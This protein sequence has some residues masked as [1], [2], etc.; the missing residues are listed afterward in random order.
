M[1]AWLDG[2]LVA[3]AM[4][5]RA[6]SAAPGPFETMGARRGEIASWD[7]HLAR[8]G[9]A[10]RRLG[11]PFVPD[12]KLRAAATELLLHNGHGD[13][14]LRLSLVPAAGGAH[15]VLVS[16]ARG[17]ALHVVRLLPTVVE[18]PANEPPRDLKLWP[19]PFYDA[20]RQQAQDGAADDGIVVAPDGAVLE[21][22]VGNLWLRLDGVW[23]T[24][25]LDGRVL[26][27]I[28]RAQVLAAARAQGLPVAERRCDLADLHRAEALAHSNAVF[29]PRPAAL[30]GVPLPTVPYVDTELWPLWRA[31][32]RD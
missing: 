6:T 15:T 24:P 16:R 5:P 18:P 25:P 19:R 10:A 28:A 14:V 20:V 2:A 22:A 13:D 31:A 11:L 12:A 9:A 32:P 3:D 7:L 27:G 29:G 8:I 4:A 17:P 26:P 1:T 23:T 21:T 30:L